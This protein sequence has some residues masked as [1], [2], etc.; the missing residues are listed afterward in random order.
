MYK[1]ETC[2]ALCTGTVPGEDAGFINDRIKEDYYLHWYV[3]DSGVLQ[4]NNLMNS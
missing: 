1:N 2:K 4:I 3:Y